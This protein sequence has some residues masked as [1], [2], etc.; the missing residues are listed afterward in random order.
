[1]GVAQIVG[2]AYLYSKG[3]L[4][5]GTVLIS[6]GALDVYKVVGKVL[7]KFFISKNNA[8]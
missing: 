8:S 6:D 5:L 1:M 4:R 2:E 7:I 3:Q